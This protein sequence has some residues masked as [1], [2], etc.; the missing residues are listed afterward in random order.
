MRALI[1]CILGVFVGGGVGFL[2][3]YAMYV[4]A[5]SDPVNGGTMRG[6]AA[7]LGI[8]TISGGML[9]GGFIG[10]VAATATLAASTEADPRHI[11]RERSTSSKPASTIRILA[12]WIWILFGAFTMVICV[13]GLLVSMARGPIADHAL[14]AA[15][16]FACS[17]FCLVA[18]SQCLRGKTRET[19]FYGIGSVVIGAALSVFGVLPPAGAIVLFGVGVLVIIGHGM[20][21]RNTIRS[22]ED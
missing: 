18:G 5:G 9:L 8:V 19:V 16:Y 11:G 12:G 15:I 3:P 4:A 21:R 22:D 10:T 1:G 7:L 2:V 14:K 17:V 20:E 6:V 13:L